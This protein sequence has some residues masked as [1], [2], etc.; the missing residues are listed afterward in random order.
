MVRVLT[1]QIFNIS[2]AKCAFL[3][4]VSSA[5]QFDRKETV[6]CI[7]GPHFMFDFLVVG[8]RTYTAILFFPLSKMFNKL[9]EI[10]STLP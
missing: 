1:A 7:D 5:F 4:A 9:Y 10:L 6:Q 8:K 2:P 3:N